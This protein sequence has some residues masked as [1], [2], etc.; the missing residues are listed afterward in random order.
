MTTGRDVVEI[1]DLLRRT[2]ARVW[3]GGGWGSDALLGRRTRD[4]RT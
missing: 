4:H 3:V 2:G 1:L